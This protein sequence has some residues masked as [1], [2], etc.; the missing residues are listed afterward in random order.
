MYDIGV[1]GPETGLDAFRMH[2][3]VIVVNKR[4]WQM[5]RALPLR[6]VSNHRRGVDYETARF[7]HLS[8]A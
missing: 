1:P 8:K 4:C 2:E 3:R 5:S 6:A 7:G